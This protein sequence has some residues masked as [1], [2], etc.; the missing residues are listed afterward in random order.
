MTP[1]RRSRFWL[2]CVLA[3]CLAGLWTVEAQQPVN[4]ELPT[5]AALSDDTANP[6]TPAIAAY[7]M[8]WDGATWDRCAVAAD[9]CSGNIKTTTPVSITTDTVVIAAV[10]AK[11]NYICNLVLVASAAEIVS[12]TEG[13]GSFCGTGEAAI[14]G[15]TTDANGLSFAANGGV[16]ISGGDATILAGKTANVDTCLN[17]S[18]SNRVS[19]FIT[20][21]QQ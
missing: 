6:T 5:A 18:G 9:P 16:S 17:V 12:I 8:C 2:G 19:G 7:L 3:A 15:S 1:S 20:W 11:K 4:T 13:T 21:V 10:S 14:L